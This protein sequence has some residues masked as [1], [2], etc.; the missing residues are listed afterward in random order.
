ME[1]KDRQFR[2]TKGTQNTEKWNGVDF[3][4]FV[5]SVVNQ[6]FAVNEMNLEHHSRFGHLEND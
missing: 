6:I 2:T 1:S 4:F 5:H 3:E